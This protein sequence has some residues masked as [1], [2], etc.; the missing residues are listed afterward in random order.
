VTSVIPPKWHRKAPILYALEPSQARE[1]V[2]RFFNQRKQ[3]RRIATRD[4]KLRQTCLAFI[5]IVA[6]WLMIR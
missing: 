1:T 3:F 5:H 4:E 6:R 2:E